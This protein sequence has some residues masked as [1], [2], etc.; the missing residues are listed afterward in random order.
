MYIFC[1]FYSSDPPCAVSQ[2][3]AF[4]H[5]EQLMLL[6][7]D[8]QKNPRLVAITS[9]K[10]KPTVPQKNCSMKNP[11]G[12]VCS[13]LFSSVFTFQQMYRY[14]C[15]S[16]TTATKTAQCAD[17]LTQLQPFRKH[18]W[19][20][21]CRSLT[22]QIAALD[23][24]L[25]TERLVESWKIMPAIKKRRI[26]QNRG[27]TKEFLKEKHTDSKLASACAFCNFIHFC[28]F[29]NYFHIAYSS[30]IAATST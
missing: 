13:A 18:S 15:L 24:V 21:C 14:A 17:C 6:T 11:S 28:A 8:L 4:N 26:R 23:N 25:N 2:N 30:I 20:N 27:I 5:P 12:S 16:L 19:I 3:T 10:T 1:C 29:W 7:L 9:P 22:T